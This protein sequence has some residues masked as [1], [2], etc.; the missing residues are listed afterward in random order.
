MSGDGDDDK[1]ECTHGD[2]VFLG[3]SLGDGTHAVVRHNGDHRIEYGTA[4]I[5]EPGQTPPNNGEHL[6]LRPKGGSVYEVRPVE[7]G[8][9]SGPAQV[10]TRAYRSGWDNIFGNKTVGQA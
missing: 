4:R 10:S 6:R 3:P 1:P 7:K 5:L 8:E 9:R 2:E